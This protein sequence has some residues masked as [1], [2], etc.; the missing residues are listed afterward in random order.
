MGGMHNPSVSVFFGLTCQRSVAAGSPGSF[1]KLALQNQFCR[2]MKNRPWALSGTGLFTSSVQAKIFAQKGRLWPLTLLACLGSLGVATAHAQAMDSVNNWTSPASAKWESPYWSLGTLPASDQTVRIM[3]D[4]YKAVNIDSTTLADFPSSLTVGSL[5]VGAPTNGLSTLL[6]NYFGLNTPLK[7]VNSCLIGTNGTLL[8]LASS[9]E[10]DGANGGTLIID[11]GTFTQ[12]AG[13][14]VASAPVQV[15][16]GSLNAT[17]ATMNLGA[18]QV[19][20]S[21]PK[22]GVFNQS[23]GTVLSSAITIGNGRY[24]LESNAVLYALAPTHVAD[25]AGDF[26]QTGGT[27]YG[28]VDV[29]LGYYT[30]QGG[31]LHG[32][33]ID[34]ITLG[35][36]DHSGGTVE[37]HNVSARGLGTDFSIF[38]G[39]RLFNTGILH[40]ATI[41]LTHWGYFRQSGGTLVLT[42]QFNLVDPAGPPVRFEFDAGNAFMPSLVVSNAGDYLQYGGT[43]EISGD[44]LLYNSAIAIYGGRL[45]TANTGIGEGSRLYN[46]GGTHEVSGVLSITGSYTLV[47]GELLVNG[48]YLR[49][50]LLLGGG[51]PPPPGPAVFENA[52]LINFGGSIFLSSSQDSMGQLQLATNGTIYLEAS[53]L[54][55]RFADSSALNWDSSSR[56]VIQGWAGSYSG[57][58]ATQLYFG[59]SSGGLTPAQLALVR[60]LDPAGSQP[61]SYNA[62]ILST[63]EVVPASPPALLSSRSANQLVLTWSGNYQLFSATNV[64][65]PYQ[66]VSG[67][68]SPY[69][70]DMRADPHRFFILQPPTAKLDVGSL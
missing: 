4:G 17:N 47:E 6:L 1:P 70:N 12:E 36:F 54:V 48:V 15:L 62:Q 10:V 49:G 40:S 60:F 68:A 23:G 32:S 64:A 3:N 2:T 34:T 30:L 53:P 21:F 35:F 43:N 44:L 29:G 26:L 50:N 22:H 39:Y 11:G 7:V 38:P 56:L 28:D 63:G 18:L 67:A 42:N 24:L 46:Q 31:L 8:N 20:G 55:V 65:G 66:P 57:N 41:T 37:V 9:F 51:S 25:G 45:V 58:G 59:N 14:T 13:L 19:G 61:G 69:T 5:E 33:N 52:G 27:Y 16:D